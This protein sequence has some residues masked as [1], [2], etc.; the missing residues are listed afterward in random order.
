MP[1]SLAAGVADGG[2]ADVQHSAVQQ[3]YAR[4]V[5]GT[6]TA[7]DEAYRRGNTGGDILLCSQLLTQLHNINYT[8][9]HKPPWNHGVYRPNRAQQ[10]KP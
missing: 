1:C 9:L 10:C 5:P 6:G 2:T 4:Y 7:I 3:V 8:F